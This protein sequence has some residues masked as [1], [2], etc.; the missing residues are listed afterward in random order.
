MQTGVTLDTIGG[1]A[2]RELFEAELNRVLANIT[3][4]NTDE[5]TKRTIALTV[6]FKPN[7]DRDIADVDLACSSKLAGITKV[8]TRLYVGRQQGK[9]I[10]IESDPR[11][12]TLFDPPRPAPIAVGDFTAK[13]GDE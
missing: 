6:T 11:Q 2:L 12:T 9:L 1:G 4:P 10:A 13:G 3:D 5:T 7:S 8:R